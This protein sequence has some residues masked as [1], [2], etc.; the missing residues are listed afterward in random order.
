MFL[1]KVKLHFDLGRIDAGLKGEQGTGDEFVDIEGAH[2]DHRLAGFDPGQVQQIVHHGGHALVF[3]DDDG[4]IFWRL[5]L[6]DGA[7]LHGFQE[8]PHGGQGGPKLMGHVGHKTAPGLFQVVEGVRHQVEALAQLG[9]LVLALGWDAQIEGALGKPQHRGVHIDDGLGDPAGDVA[10]RQKGR[11]HRHAGIEQHV[12]PHLADGGVDAAHI[13]MEEQG[14][15]DIALP[16][17]YRGGKGHHWEVHPVPE[18]IGDDAPFLLAG[19]DGRRHRLHIQVLAARPF[20]LGGLVH[21][22]PLAEL[23]VGKAQHD[24]GVIFAGGDQKL[25]LRHRP[26]VSIH[27]PAGHGLI[28]LLGL[29]AQLALLLPD[30]LLLKHAAHRNAQQEK[31]AQRY[32][33]VGGQHT[34]KQGLEHLFFRLE[35]IAYT[36]YG[37]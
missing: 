2:M 24:Q 7:V 32:G 1:G 17:L 23:V 29:P 8:A 16:V 27:I 21:K 12:H 18:H 19:Q 9:H 22:G 5:L 13:R 28:D 26:L 34:G 33:Q 35:F 3:I 11:K 14:G 30:V 20:I 6:G 36:P 25:L 10:H 4:Q 15:D 31:Q 37:L